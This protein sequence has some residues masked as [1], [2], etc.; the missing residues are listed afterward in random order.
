MLHLIVYKTES[1]LIAFCLFSCSPSPYLPSVEV[2]TMAALR[3]FL[4]VILL[5]S[6]ATAVPTYTNPVLDGDHPDP[7]TEGENQQTKRGSH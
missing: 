6:M 1:S 2:L 3:G 4:A 7:G 5:G